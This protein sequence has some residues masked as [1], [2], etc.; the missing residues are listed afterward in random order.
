MQQGQNERGTGL[1]N[2]QSRKTKEVTISKLKVM[3]GGNI[4]PAVFVIEIH[5]LVCCLSRGL[6]SSPAG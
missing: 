6:E 5:S 1:A 3:G 4:S 2:V